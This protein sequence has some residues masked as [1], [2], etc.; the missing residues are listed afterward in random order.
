[1]AAELLNLYQTQMVA[2]YLLQHIVN[3]EKPKKIVRVDSEAAF[4]NEDVY[5]ENI[6][7]EAHLPLL[8]VPGKYAGMVREGCDD[9]GKII[10]SNTNNR[11]VIYNVTAGLKIVNDM[12]IVIQ[13]PTSLDSDTWAKERKI[14]EEQVTQCRQVTCRLLIAAVNVLP[15]EPEL[16][17][18]FKDEPEAARMFTN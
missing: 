12:G 3:G 13:K 8:E 7:R 9:G 18:T 5:H 4:G 17:Y 2:D 6:A 15:D 1:M 10:Y 14:W 11:I 16:F